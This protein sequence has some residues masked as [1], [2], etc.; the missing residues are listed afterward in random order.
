MSTAP[1]NAVP[2]AKEKSKLEAESVNLVEVFFQ[3]LTYISPGTSLA[4]V[5]P[6]VAVFAGGAL[7][8]VVTFIFFGCIATAWLLGELSAKLPSSGGFLTYI[9]HGFGPNVGFMAGWLYV[10]CLLVDVGGIFLL[11]SGFVA[12]QLNSSWH[13]NSTAVWLVV[14]LILAAFVTMNGLRRARKGTRLGAILGTIEVVAFAV[15][16]IWLIFAAGSRNSFQV[17]TTHYANAPNYKGMSGIFAAG[18]LTILAYQGFESAVVLGEEAKTPKISIKK[19]MMIS[20]VAI[21]GYF[22]LATYASTV[23]YGAAR[24]VNFGSYG[25]GAPWDQLARDVWGGG[26]VIIFLAIVNSVT[27]C[28]NAANIATTRTLFAMSRA[29]VLPARLAATNKENVPGP[30]QILTTVVA[31][32][33]AIVTAIIWGP[34]PA[35]TFLLT[36]TSGIIIV[37]YMVA[38]VGCVSVYYRKFRSEFS[39]VRHVIPAIVVWA[40]FIPA[41][42]ATFGIRAFR[43]VSPLAWP[44]KLVAPIIIGWFIVGVV[45]GVYVSR[46]KS[47]GL[48]GVQDVY[49]EDLSL[50]KE[51]VLE[52]LG[53]TE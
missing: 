18:V 34:M 8:L 14:T 51:D 22:I 24:M 26:W 39:I 9:S 10:L 45:V 40:A 15:L 52:E 46:T 3:S 38:A 27:A 47:R 30:A 12:A 33:A 43:F 13:W 7:P 32:T 25:N 36:I 20:V 2:I 37:L 35:A 11:L 41:F 42:L 5:L 29:G 31:L 48:S 1:D 17:F 6:F 50:L 16:S 21:L 19:G 44:E 28:A 23:Y 4:L 53:Q 49:S